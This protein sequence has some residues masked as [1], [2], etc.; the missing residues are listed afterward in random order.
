MQNGVVAHPFFSVAVAFYQTQIRLVAQVHPKLSHLSNLPN[1]KS[2]VIRGA[3]QRN[4][5]I[6]RALARPPAWEIPPRENPDQLMQQSWIF[7][8]EGR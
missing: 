4:R 1:V 8:S 5:G 2:I 3:A 7:F 6:S